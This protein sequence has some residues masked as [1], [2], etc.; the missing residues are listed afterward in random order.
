MT[1]QIKTTAEHLQKAPSGIAGLDEI[2]FGGLPRGRPTLI[3]GAAGCGKTLFALTFLVKG[4]TVYDE[5]GVFMTFE[6][7]ADD[8]VQNVGSLGYDLPGLI[9]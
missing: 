7:R 4:A 2:T 6:E 9:A 8:L 1:Q 5:P 3:A